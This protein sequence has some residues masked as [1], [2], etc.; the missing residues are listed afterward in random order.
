MGDGMGLIR[1]V[2]TPLTLRA[3]SPSNFVYAHNC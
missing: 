2:L 1:G 3:A